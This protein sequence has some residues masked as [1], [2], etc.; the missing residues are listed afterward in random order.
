MEKQEEKK[1]RKRG[2]ERERVMETT[3]K[4]GAEY[5][6]ENL[7]PGKQEDVKF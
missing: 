6:Q 5:R 4:C 2:R 7:K 3:G 1:G